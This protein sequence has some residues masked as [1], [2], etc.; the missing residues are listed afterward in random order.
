[1]LLTTEQG[2]SASGSFAR[3]HSASPMGLRVP[4]SVSLK[5]GTSNKV[6]LLDL[7]KGPSLRFFKKKKRKRNFNHPHILILTGRPTCISGDQMMNGFIFTVALGTQTV[8]H[9][10]GN[11]T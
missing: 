1:M 3:I 2:I 5:A 6:M 9:L 11:S 10:G 4:G 8:A 7:V